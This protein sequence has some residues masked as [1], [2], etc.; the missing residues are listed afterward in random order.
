MVKVHKPKGL[1]RY[2]SYNSIQN[3]MA[4][5][6]TPRVIGYSFVLLVLAVLFGFSLMTR[7]DV[8]TN[9]FKI[10]GTLYQKSEDGFITNLYNVEFV[11][12]TFEDVP[13]EVKVESPSWASLVKA[14]G[15]P[16]I[17]PAGGLL[18][19]IYFVRIPADKIVEAKTNVLLGVYSKGERMETLKIKF[20]G[21]VAIKS[22]P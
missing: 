5:L 3:G 20:I 6:I 19:S 2:A 16:V 8:K 17:A 13:I 14:D 22:K 15:S 9:I 12:K 10:P 21:P 1:I 7:S 4:K 11:N 18:K